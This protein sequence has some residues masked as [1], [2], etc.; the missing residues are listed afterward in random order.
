MARNHRSRR[1]KASLVTILENRSERRRIRV[2]LFHRLPV[3]RALH[4]RQG[5]EHRPHAAHTGVSPQTIP[6]AAEVYG[7]AVGVIERIVRRA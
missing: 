3:L 5:V 1:R 2:H 4:R 7:V 6:Q